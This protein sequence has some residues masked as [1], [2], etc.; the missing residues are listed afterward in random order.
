MTR[1]RSRKGKPEHPDDANKRP[2]L[3][4]PPLDGRY[5]WSLSAE[6]EEEAPSKTDATET[7]TK[8]EMVKIVRVLLKRRR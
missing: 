4:A 2:T 8:F 5:R 1:E 6:D 7:H 3:P